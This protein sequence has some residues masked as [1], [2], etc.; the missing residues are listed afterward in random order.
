[1]VEISPRHL[2]WENTGKVSLD[3]RG[4]L[5]DLGATG[6]WHNTLIASAGLPGPLALCWWILHSVNCWPQSI[7]FIKGTACRGQA[8]G[9]ALLTGQTRYQ[10]HLPRCAFIHSPPS[11]LPT[12]GR[13]GLVT[14]CSIPPLP[15]CTA[16]WT[17]PL[18]LSAQQWLQFS[19]LGVGDGGGC[20]HRCLPYMYPSRYPDISPTDIS[21]TDSS[22]TDISPTD[23]SPTD[24]S[25]KSPK[26][27]FRQPYI[28]TS[29]LRC[30]ILINPVITVPKV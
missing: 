15:G 8:S 20:G 4:F 11:S 28:F 17:S 13:Y 6:D 27:T 10:S 12:Q 18:V 23:S 2:G 22:P 1:M 21:P 9:Y 16:P 26:R 5:C 3:H 24:I 25:S 7:L 29:K 30:Y 19:L 14:H